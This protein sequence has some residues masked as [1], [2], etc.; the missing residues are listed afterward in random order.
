MGLFGSD[1]RVFGLDIGYETI[2]LIEIKK[3]GPGY[4]LV[5]FNE[6]PLGERLLEKDH[7]KNIASAANLIVE[8]T[9][10]S[11]PQ[12][13]KAKRIVSALPESFVFSK[14]I[15]MPKMSPAELEKSIPIEAAQYVPIP[16]E[17]LYIDYQVLTMSPNSTM[18]DILLVASPKKLVDDYM[19]MAKLAGMELFAL[20]TK[21]IAVGRAIS[22]SKSLASSV[23]IEIGTEIT[24]LSIWNNN[25]V[26]LITSVPT[27]KNQITEAGGLGQSVSAPLL[28]NS[29]ALS[30]VKTITDETITAIKYHQNRAHNPK[31]ITE[32]YLC[33]SGAKIE[34]IDEYIKKMI[35]IKTE[36]V[37]PNISGPAELG[38][39]FITSFGLSLCN[40]IG[41]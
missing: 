32:I 40:T 4:A 30:L 2:K 11:K 17:N 21:P 5:G 39:E 25:Y 6:V 33:G 26:Q 20:E 37:K 29:P 31:P 34:G 14:M 7:F 1:N 13:I 12:A 19:E 24:R 15:E 10:K 36:I 28:Q 22:A 9:S 35:R 3:S 8:A 16:V 41:Q 27:G 38:T 18:T 23:I